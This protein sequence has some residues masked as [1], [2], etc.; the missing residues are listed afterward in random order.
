M[1]VLSVVQFL[2]NL[3]RNLDS[4]HTVKQKKFPF[5]VVITHGVNSDP[6]RW[7]KFFFSHFFNPTDFHFFQTTLKYFFEN[8]SAK[9]GALKRWV[10]LKIQFLLLFFIFRNFWEGGSVWW[11]ICFKAFAFLLGKLTSSLFTLPL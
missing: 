1:I 8:F 10:F 3:L 7:L 5:P 11:G 9:R 4:L 6:I 2:E